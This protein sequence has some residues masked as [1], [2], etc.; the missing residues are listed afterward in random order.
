MYYILFV[1]FTL[2][3]YFIGIILW[4]GYFNGTSLVQCLD[5][6]ACEKVKPRLHWEVHLLT[7]KYR[8]V[9]IRKCQIGPN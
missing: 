7:I 3:E 8:S 6:N 4:L 9:N 2:P 5:L 1:A